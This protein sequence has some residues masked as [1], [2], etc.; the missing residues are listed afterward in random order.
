MVLHHLGVIAFQEGD[1]RQATTLIGQAIALRP[2]YADAYSNLGSALVQR[3]RL[4]DAT[5]AFR[6][7]LELKPDCIAAGSL[8]TS[9]SHAAGLS[10]IAVCHA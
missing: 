2:D 7:A 4:E 5:A 3:G 8:D 6:T 1:P 9:L 10:D